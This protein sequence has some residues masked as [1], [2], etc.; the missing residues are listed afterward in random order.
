ML[1][2]INLPVVP[3]RLPHVAAA[4][5]YD[6]GGV[7]PALEMTA[8]KLSFLVLFIAGTLEMHLVLHFVPG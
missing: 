2:A 3:V 1:A 7:V 4:L 6:I 8:T 5:F